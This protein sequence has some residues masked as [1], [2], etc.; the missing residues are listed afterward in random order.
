MQDLEQLPRTHPQ[1]R[2][3]SGTSSRTFRRLTCPRRP[4]KTVGSR[5]ARMAAV[6]QTQAVLDEPSRRLGLCIFGTSNAHSKSS[7]G[8]EWLDLF[9]KDVDSISA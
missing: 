7:D 9:Q 2:W 4:G 5:P 1:G 3:P 8:K 6:G